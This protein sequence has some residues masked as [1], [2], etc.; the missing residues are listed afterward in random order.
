MFVIRPYIDGPKVLNRVIGDVWVQGFQQAGVT[1]RGLDLVSFQLGL[2]FVDIGLHPVGPDYGPFADVVLDVQPSE[3]IWVA[4]GGWEAYNPFPT[5][6][7]PTD[8][9]WILSPG[10]GRSFHIDTQSRRRVNPEHSYALGLTVSHNGQGGPGAD[11][12]QWR[13][14]MYV[15]TLLGN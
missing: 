8:G 10:Q 12:L 3:Y 7:P 6:P 4:A 15:R 14:Q 1:P 5:D 9:A 2:F 13:P 11:T